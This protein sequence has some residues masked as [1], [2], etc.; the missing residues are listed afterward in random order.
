MLW[1]VDGYV[2]FGRTQRA[3]HRS[4]EF[5]L[6]ATVGCRIRRFCLRGSTLV[7]CVHSPS[8]SAVTRRVDAWAVVVC[9]WMDVWTLVVAGTRFLMGCTRA[10][11]ATCEL[12]YG[13]VLMGHST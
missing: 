1:A 13:A 5:L 2:V 3:D 11:C 8:C 7:C 10:S 6:F 4:G 12:P 9:R